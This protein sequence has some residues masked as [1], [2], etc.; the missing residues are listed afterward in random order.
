MEQSQTTKSEKITIFS[1]LFPSVSE[2]PEMI[3][4]VA[5][6]ETEIIIVR[7]PV[8]WGR[9]WETNNKRQTEGEVIS[10]IIEMY[11]LKSPVIMNSWLV[12]CSSSGREEWIEVVKKKQS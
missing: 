7:H 9:F 11:M 12:S 6:A 3:T 10:R 8:H 4:C 2:F 1:V 5:Y